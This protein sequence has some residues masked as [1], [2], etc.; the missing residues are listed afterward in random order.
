MAVFFKEKVSLVNTIAILLAFCGL[1]FLYLGDVEQAFY[2][3]GCDYKK[4]EPS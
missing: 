2:F 3:I 4:Y 1:G